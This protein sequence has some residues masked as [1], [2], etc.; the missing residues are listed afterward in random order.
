MRPVKLSIVLD[1]LKSEGFLSGDSVLCNETDFE[2]AG[3][4]SVDLAGDA[5]ASF[6]VGD[7]VKSETN[8]NGGRCMPDCCLFRAVLRWI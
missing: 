5:D 2:I 4:A 8:A 7:T 6:W 3:F 1:W